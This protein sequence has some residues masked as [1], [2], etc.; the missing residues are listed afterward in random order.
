[1]IVDLANFHARGQKLGCYFALIRKLGAVTSSSGHLTGNG[2][3]LKFEAIANAYFVRDPFVQ[4]NNESKLPLSFS[5]ANE[6]LGFRTCFS[7]LP[8]TR[9]GNVWTSKT[10]SHIAVWHHGPGISPPSS[11]QAA[12]RVFVSLLETRM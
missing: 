6:V 7:P 9:I 8:T 3:G 2:A 10:N 4:I 5:A 11:V 12:V 1:M